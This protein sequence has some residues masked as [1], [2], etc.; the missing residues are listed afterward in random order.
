MKGIETAWRQLAGRQHGVVSHR[1]LAALGL[2]DRQIFVRRQREELISAF[3]GAYLLAGSPATHAQSLMAA[4]LATGGVASHRSAAELWGLRGCEGQT[5][6]MLVCVRRRSELPGVIGHATR[7]LDAIDVTTR[8]AIP[9]TTPARTLVDLGAVAP[10]EVVEGALED[11]LHRRLVTR[12]WLER[13]LTRG[14]APGRDGAGTLRR[15]LLDRPVDRRPTESTLEDEIVRIIR[16]AGLPEPVR[17]HPVGRWR[18]DVSYPDDRIAIEGQSMGWHA[19]RADL[20]RDCD[21]FNL[22]VA[23]G[24]RLLL[25]TWD[26]AR[27]RPNHVVDTVA[28]ALTVAACRGS[29][30]SSTSGPFS[31]AR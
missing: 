30:R 6:E 12:S 7:Q 29:G 5:V 11:A 13:T 24:W 10:V 1:Q 27:R 8:L 3:R 14:C 28:G 25:F 2:S 21:K 15:L 16:R 31:S 26:D 19:G 23:L 22:L 20:Q 17:Q 9:V 18:I 4:C